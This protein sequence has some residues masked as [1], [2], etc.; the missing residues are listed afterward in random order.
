[1]DGLDEARR[2]Q[3]EYRRY[4]GD[5]RLPVLAQHPSCGFDHGWKLHGR[6]RQKF[7][8]RQQVKG[9]TVESGVLGA[10]GLP[11]DF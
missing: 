2:R 7:L 10:R 1:M 6:A 5:R 8:K 11:S 3:F 9:P 4:V